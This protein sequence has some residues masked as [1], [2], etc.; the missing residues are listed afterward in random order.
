MARALGLPEGQSR[1]ISGQL[2]EP[3]GNQIAPAD[4]D[5]GD[6]RR[7][8]ANE[9]REAIRQAADYTKKTQGL[10]E[11]QR[12]VQAQHA[13]L[14]QV[15]PFIQPELQRLAQIVQGI[16]MP[17]I[18]LLDSNPNQYHR[19][20]ALYQRAMA[21]QQRLAQLN[22]VQSEAQARA[23]AQAL[24]V[25]NAQLSAEFPA[26][27]DPIQRKAWQTELADWA[28]N[29]AGYT[30]AELS[31]L[32]DARHL[33]TMMKAYQ[34]DLMV[35]G[36]QTRAPAAPAQTAQLRGQ[37]PPPAPAASV[38]RAEQAFDA[39]PNVRNGAALVAARR[40]AAN[41]NGSAGRW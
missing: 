30:H 23:Q 7:Y 11:Q 34:F 20:Y 14:A 10:A 3:A 2:A 5:L 6:G 32:V 26:W 1:E 31:N 19:E 36:A 38:Q 18:N 16:P 27:G 37:R 4:F 21:E 29:K 40:A 41:G 12:H 33:R 22:N 39:R 24:E 9:L 13:A 28:I 35:S 17:D 8:S 25:A 15:L